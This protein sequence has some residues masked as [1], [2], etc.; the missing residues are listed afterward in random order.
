MLD[1]LQDNPQMLL[2]VIIG[3]VVIASLGKGG[4]GAPAVNPI[5]ELAMRAKL[6]GEVMTANTRARKDIMDTLINYDDRAKMHREALERMRLNHSAEM[7]KAA[8]E[9]RI[10]KANAAANAAMQEKALAAERDRM[11]YQQQA[12]DRRAFFGVFNGFFRGV[13]KILTFGLV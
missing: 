10:A 6:Q 11:R 1:S 7:W 5:E 13:L 12:E 8:S 9:E 3:V 2:L 4:G